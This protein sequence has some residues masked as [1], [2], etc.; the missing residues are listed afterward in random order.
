MRVGGGGAHAIAAYL[1]AY[2]PAAPEAFNAWLIKGAFKKAVLRRWIVDMENELTKV[3]VVGENVHSVRARRRTHANQAE[4]VRA[5]ARCVRPI[6]AR[7]GYQGPA[8]PRAC[9][10]REGKQGRRLD[11]AIVVVGG[12]I[13]GVWELTDNEVEGVRTSLAT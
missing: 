4:Q 5:A 10:P 13:T 9:A 6:R 2:G 12:R 8:R 1:G 11:R 7:T 3:D